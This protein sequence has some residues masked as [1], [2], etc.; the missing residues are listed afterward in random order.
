[1]R[2]NRIVLIIL[3]VGMTGCDFKEEV[4]K[5]REEARREQMR[6]NLE[7]INKALQN[8]EKKYEGADAVGESTGDSTKP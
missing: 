5:R 6:N 3:S 1:M 7:Q 2:L 4:R 8:Y